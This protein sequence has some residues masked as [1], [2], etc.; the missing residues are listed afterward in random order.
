MMDKALR[1]NY[2]PGSTFKIVPTIAALED[3]LVDPDA[4]VTCYGGLRFGKRMFHCAE[5]HG[6]IDLH[7][8]LA[9]SCDVY[10]YELGA[11]ARARSHGARG[12]RPRLRRADRH[13]AQRRVAGPG[14][15]D[16]LLQAHGGRVP[17]GLPLE[18]GDRAGRRQGDRAAGGDGLRG[19]R[20]RRQAVGA[21]DRRARAIA[22]RAHGAGVRA[23]VAPADC[24][25]GRHAAEGALG[26]ARH[27]QPPEGQR[28]RGARARARCVGQDRHRADGQE[29]QRGRRGRREQQPLVVRQLRAA[30]KAGDRGG[31]ARRAR[32]LR[33]QG[34][35]ADGDGDLRRL[36]RQGHYG[37]TH[38][39]KKR[40]ARRPDGRRQ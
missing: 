10:Y 14:A 26:A 5:T 20:Q 11:D 12:A 18:H 24:G 19:H 30:A 3:H 28:L 21:A 31:R 4:I 25:V 8:A 39:P 32:R 1:E 9:E 13:R 7:F 33:R 35:G 2:F 40:Q 6:K 34:V 37:S 27:R 15:V 17:E 16:G 29:P 22:R 38:E 36:L 23:A